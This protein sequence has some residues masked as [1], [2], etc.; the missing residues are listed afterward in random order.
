MQTNIYIGLLNVFMTLL[1]VGLSIPLI[2]RKVKMNHVYG[3]RIQKSFKLDEDWY[4]L[5]EYG[6]KQLVLWSIPI[7]VIGLFCFSSLFG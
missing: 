6:G 2:L 7:L 4:A 1:T 3:A 5:N